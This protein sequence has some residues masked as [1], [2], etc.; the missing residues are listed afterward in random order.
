MTISVVIPAYNSAATIQATLNSVLQQTVQPDEILVMDD[1]S[2]DSTA[3][4]LDSYKPLIIV[5]RQ[6]NSGVA[7]ARNALCERARGDLIAFLDHDDLWHPRYLEHQ[8]R[9][10]RKHSDAVAF[11]AGHVDFYGYGNYDWKNSEFDPEAGIEV[12]DPLSFFKRF[13]AKSGSFGSGS[14]VCVPK[15][16]LAEIGREPFCEKVSGVDD[17]YLCGRLALLG[18]VVF[19]PAPLVA[20]RVTK[21]AQSENKLKAK[22]LMVECYKALEE[23]YGLRPEGKLYE[24]FR[25]AFAAARRQYAKG[26]M[27]AGMTR[28][29]RRQIWS[30]LANTN[31]PVSLGKSL[32]LLLLSCMPAA[33]Q[34]KWPP[35]YREWKGSSHS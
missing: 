16:I 8:Q 5:F 7:S 19:A 6:A 2:T 27:G 12:L 10:F 29:A 17:G 35:I 4:L 23:H 25:M 18:H 34:P 30:S 24:A 20:Y 31:H 22:G 28:E 14:F 21:E 33:L 9:Q 11:Y 15:R 1:G 13:D 32:G 3:S 26:L